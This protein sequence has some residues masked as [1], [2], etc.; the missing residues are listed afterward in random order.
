[1]ITLA[2]L[3]TG[4]DWE[5]RLLAVAEAAPG[6]VVLRR[7]VDVPDLVAAC[8]TGQIQL[9]VVGIDAPELDREIVSGL[10]AS[11]VRTLAVALDPERE[12]VLARA[13][14]IG[15]STLLAVADLGD[16]PAMA[17]EC[18][19]GP[20][21]VSPPTAPSTRHR[22]IAIWGPHGAPGRSTLAAA[23]A[24]CSARKR[25]TV[26]IDADPS[27]PSQAQQLGIMDEASGL[28]TA[29]RAVASG[30]RGRELL[31]LAAR[32]VGSSL[33]VITGLPGPERWP[34]IRPDVLPTLLAAAGERAEVL[35]DTGAEWDDT[36]AD[37]AGRGQRFSLTGESLRRADR[38]LVTG[39]ADPVGLTR[40][41][42]GLVRLREV[43]EVRPERVVV[44]R[45]RSGVGWTEPEV[46]DLITRVAGR[47]PVDFL[48][49]DPRSAD[50]A[51]LSGRTVVEIGSS[52]LAGAVTRLAAQLW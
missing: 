37:P 3:A 20:T 27:A 9:A 51:A 35:L 49:D 18:L 11:G 13:T 26:L 4:A 10:A 15:T 38:I 21:P 52:Q 33:D 19:V 45:M 46:R 25:P 36:G 28:L 48:P 41:A 42:R 24:V 16:L 30:A 22:V 23:L 7:C 8:G 39:T 6:I 14:R 34:E 31:G 47:V 43:A 1:M 2:V 40:L 5:Q 44:N 29:A 17:S 12:D 50:R 32:R